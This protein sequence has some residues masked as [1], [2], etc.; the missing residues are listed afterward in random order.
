LVHLPE[1]LRY[2]SLRGI[3]LEEADFETLSRFK[4]IAG[5]TIDENLINDEV[6]SLMRRLHLGRCPS[7]GENGE[8]SVAFAK[9]RT[10]PLCSEVIG[11]EEAV[12]VARP[13]SLDADLSR[14]VKVPMHWHCYAQWELRPRFAHQYFQANIDSMRHND[15]WGIAQCD[16]RVLLTVN[17]SEYVKEIDVLLAETGSS[18]RIPLR[19]WE[20]WLAGQW[21]EGCRHEVECEILAEL[22]PTWQSL[23][24]TA[25]AVIEAAGYDDGREI[26]KQSPMLER[27]CYEFACDKLVQRA[28]QKGL[29]CP[30]C[31]N[32]SNEFI[33]HRVETVSLEGARS[34]LQCTGCKHEFGP[35]EPGLP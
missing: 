30:N 11:E 5:I 32:Y 14:Y 10:C 29:A 22:V 23:L 7:Y 16:R 18:I 21:F 31:G 25:E 28:L 12:F 24:P 8:G 4:A 13:F 20:D 27:I 9:L 2:L 17:P 6:L 33:Y 35:N 34:C 15:Y 1:G 26:P 3:Q 19:E